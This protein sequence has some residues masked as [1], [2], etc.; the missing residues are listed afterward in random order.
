MCNEQRD[1]VELVALDGQVML[2]R[3]VRLGH[4]RPMHIKVLTPIVEP[5]DGEGSDNWLWPGKT[6]E[7]VLTHQTHTNGDGHVRGHWVT[8]RKV[9]NIWFR[10][11]S[12]MARAV[13]ENPFNVQSKNCSIEML[14]FTDM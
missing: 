12:A 14:V 1:N 9:T 5:N 6:L 4:E 8:Y 7:C 3:L 11:D 2:V 10:V 13:I